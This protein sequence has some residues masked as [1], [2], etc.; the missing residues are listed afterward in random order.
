MTRKQKLLVQGL[1]TAP[2]TMERIFHWGVGYPQSHLNT[3][4]SQPAGKPNPTKKTINA[5]YFKS[6]KEVQWE[7]VNEHWEVNWVDI[8]GKA[9]AR[10][11][12]VRHHGLHAK[13]MAWE[14][15]NEL[16]RDGKVHE[17]QPS[18]RKDGIYYEEKIGSW[19]VP[20]TNP[21]TGQRDSKAFS[22]ADYGYEGGRQLA[23]KFD[24]WADSD[25][26]KFTSFGCG[27][28]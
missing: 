7:E 11:F 3:R 9:H 17:P 19:L 8:Q 24:P 28:N 12:P 6:T 23:E 13:T 20:F 22:V 10:G 21:E 4:I 1:T 14:F 27:G 16:K 15:F 26:S 18:G 5:T 25:I 2:L